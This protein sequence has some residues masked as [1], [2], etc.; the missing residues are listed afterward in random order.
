MSGAGMG[1]QER[2]FGKM[3]GFLAGGSEMYALLGEGVE[4]LTVEDRLRADRN[5]E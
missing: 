5:A 2:N 3:A 4:G 1:Q